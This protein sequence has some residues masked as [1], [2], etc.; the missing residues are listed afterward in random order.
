MTDPTAEKPDFRA[1]L[2]GPLAEPGGTDGSWSGG[3][4][5]VEV[6]PVPDGPCRGGGALVS[7]ESV[8]LRLHDARNLDQCCNVPNGGH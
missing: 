6:V 8:P 1:G 5:F 7:V 2:L 4:N 3:T